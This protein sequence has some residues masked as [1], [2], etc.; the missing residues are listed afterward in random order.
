MV[1][2]YQQFIRIM[3]FHYFGD[4]A[5]NVLALQGATQSDSGII[6]ND[7][8]VDRYND[9]IICMKGTGLSIFTGTVDPGLYYI[10][11]PMNP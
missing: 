4:D 10:K 2:D 11:K 9:L 6:P 5:F 1:T 7:N 8:E 3:G